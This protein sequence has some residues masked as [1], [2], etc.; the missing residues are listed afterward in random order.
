MGRIQK[1]KTTAAKKKKKQPS[2][3]GNAVQQ[4]A[5][6]AVAK[7]PAPSADKS[8]RAVAKRNILPL[9]KQSN[10]SAAVSARPKDNF[11]TK[12]AQ[13]LREVKV[14]LKK[15]T[16]PSRKQT[17]GSTLVVIILV[18]I[19]SLFLGAV[20]MGLSSLIRVVFQ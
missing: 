16:W 18:M 1:K 14:E 17:I 5:T 10:D 3:E 13:F 20:D 6:D 8:N 12:T 7:G 4:Q 15:V 2:V 19:I 9:K 11:L